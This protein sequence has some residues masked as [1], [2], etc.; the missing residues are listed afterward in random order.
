MKPLRAFFTVASQNTFKSAA[1]DYTEELDEDH[2]RLEIRRYWV[3]D[4]MTTRGQ[5]KHSGVACAA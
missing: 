1:Y 2:G 5:T 4:D 3:S